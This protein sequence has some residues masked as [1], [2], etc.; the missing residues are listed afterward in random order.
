MFDKFEE[1]QERTMCIS[2]ARTKRKTVKG[3]HILQHMHAHSFISTSA[4]LRFTESERTED[5]LLLEA[6]GS[7]E[8]GLQ[9]REV[10]GSPLGRARQ[11]R[12]NNQ[13]TCRT[14]KI[15]SFCPLE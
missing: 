4:S 3:V 11:N 7:G 14:P 6:K 8:A 2:W 1:E 5:Q 9:Q 10:L 13:K 15:Q 12:T